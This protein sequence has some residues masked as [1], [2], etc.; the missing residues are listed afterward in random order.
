MNNLTSFLKI[1]VFLFVFILV[2]CKDKEEKITVDPE[3]T[4]FAMI[5]RD[6]AVIFEGERSSWRLQWVVPNNFFLRKMSDD[7]DD[8]VSI[9]DLGPV[10]NLGE[11]NE[12][13]IVQR[14][15][16]PAINNNSMPCTPGHGYVIKL[17]GR[18]YWRT[19]HVR[20]MV[21][22]PVISHTGTTIGAK[23]KYQFPFMPGV[24]EEY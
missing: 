16:I 10:N 9:C 4:V 14:F 5:S 24:T 23:I 22:E 17:E 7:H 19:Y 12:I 15:S 20:L 6:S 11:I 3:D 18:F 13:P 1:I 21:E 8:H 2:S